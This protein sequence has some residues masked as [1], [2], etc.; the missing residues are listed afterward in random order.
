MKTNVSHA[1][2]ILN[3]FV[4]F[5]LFLQHAVEKSTRTLS[6]QPNHQDTVTAL[7]LSES[8]CERRRHIQ[9]LIDAMVHFKPRCSLSLCVISIC[10]LQAFNK[11]WERVGHPLASIRQ[12]GCL[13][14]YHDLCGSWRDSPES[15]LRSGRLLCRTGPFISARAQRLFLWDCGTAV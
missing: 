4:P 1:L 15:E 2:Y 8:T 9:G 7:R 11:E 3:L 5:S 6:A 10:C 13:C 14:Q 12:A